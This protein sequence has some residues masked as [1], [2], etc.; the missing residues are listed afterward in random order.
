MNSGRARENSSLPP[1][2][3]LFEPYMNPKDVLNHSQFTF[4]FSKMKA[5]FL[6]VSTL[7]VA[8]N[9]MPRY[10]LVP[11]EQVQYLRPMPMVHHRVARSAWPQAPE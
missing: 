8:A 11:I 5:V 10:V 3:A 9:A 4:H 7:M 6:V 2:V 1:C